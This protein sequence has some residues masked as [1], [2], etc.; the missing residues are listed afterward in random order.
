[1]GKT[2][3]FVHRIRN[4]VNVTFDTSY[5]LAKIIQIELN[6]VQDGGST[7]ALKNRK[8]FSGNIQLL[9]LKGTVSGGATSIILKGY[10]DDGGTKLLLP[11]S[12]SSLEDAVNGSTKSAT[13]KVDIY[14][15]SAHDD[16]YIFAKTDAGTF[17]VTEVQVAWFE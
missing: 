17:T 5:G 11:P 14:H 16:L 8:V 10:E 12:Q 2:G 1:M 3:K 7:G 9:R 13:F 15:A 6:K 4:S